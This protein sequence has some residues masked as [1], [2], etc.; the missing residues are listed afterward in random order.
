MSSFIDFFKDYGRILEI[1]LIAI[2]IAVAVYSVISGTYKTSKKKERVFGTIV[3][4]T[5]VVTAKEKKLKHKKEHF[6]MIKKAYRDYMYF[7]GKKKNIIRWLL[8]G[9]I[10]YVLIFFALSQNIG[11]G[12]ILGLNWF[13]VYYFILTNGNEKKRKKFIKQFNSALR[14][15]SSSLE[16]SNTFR[17]AIE[18][19]AKKDTITGKLH[20]EFVRLD[21]QLKTNISLN[22]ALK[23]FQKRNSLFPEV[24]MFC[25]VISFAS[26][27]GEEGIKGIIFQLEETLQQR[28]DNYLE[29]DSEIS[30]YK[31]V[32]YIVLGVSNVAPMLLPFIKPEFWTSHEN[33]LGVLKLIV[34][35]LLNFVSMF[36]FKKFI[37]S[38]AEG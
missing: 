32:F 7:G 30:L 16:A 8:L 9:Y 20:A 28:L 6:A 36:L 18:N 15:I 31:I 1:A 38:S 29:I 34:S 22:T 12:L 24:N 27:K 5:S 25:T 4:N 14:V 23:D 13:T 21:N 33:F 17:M 26:R 19:V 10:G 11:F 35:P 3:P 37:N 2:V